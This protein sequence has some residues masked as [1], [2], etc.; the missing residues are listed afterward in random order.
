MFCMQKRAISSVTF[1]CKNG[2]AK[3]KIILSKSVALHRQLG[4]LTKLCV[5]IFP[6]FMFLFLFQLHRVLFACSPIRWPRFSYILAFI[7]D[8]T[9]P[10][11]LGLTYAFMVLGIVMV[12][13]VMNAWTEYLGRLCALHA[14]TILTHVVFSKVSMLPMCGEGCYYTFL[15]LA[16]C[17]IY[18]CNV[19]LIQSVR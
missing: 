17:T 6:C 13:S 18:F 3:V 14:R 4:V 11:W 1:V 15:F 10:K 8:P 5:G 9:Q 12:S 2:G 7:S 19:Y 16:Y